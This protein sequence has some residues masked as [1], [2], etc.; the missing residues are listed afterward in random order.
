MFFHL[1]LYLIRK[2]DIFFG[3]DLTSPIPIHLIIFLKLTVLVTGGLEPT[4]LLEL[5]TVSLHQG[6]GIVPYYSWYPHLLPAVDLPMLLLELL[7]LFRRPFFF[8][9]LLEDHMQVGADLMKQF[10]VFH[11][12]GNFRDIVELPIESLFNEVNLLHF[13]VLSQDVDHLHFLGEFIAL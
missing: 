9:L 1:R 12:L 4:T 7:I 8:M 2:P 10:S 3:A 6:I 13:D 5:G 11:L